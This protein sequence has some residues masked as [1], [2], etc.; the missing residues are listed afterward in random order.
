MLDLEFLEDNVEHV[1]VFSKILTGT[2][3]VTSKIE[4]HFSVYVIIF[5]RCSVSGE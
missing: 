1:H 3:T 5:I 2:G 4:L